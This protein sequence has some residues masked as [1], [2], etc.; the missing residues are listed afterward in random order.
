MRGLTNNWFKSFLQDR[1]QYTNINPFVPNAPFL[2][3]LK[4]SENLTV[5]WCFQGVEKGYIGNEWVKECSSK[6]LLIT[7]GVPQGSIIGPLLFLLYINDL[8]KAIMHCPV[9]HFADDTNLLFIG[10]RLKKLT[11]ILTMTWDIFVNGS[12]ATG[13]Q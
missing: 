3:Q 6:N 10:N 1:C 13:Y 8:H 2:Y 12:R 4:A 11:N 5:F 7:P 9:H